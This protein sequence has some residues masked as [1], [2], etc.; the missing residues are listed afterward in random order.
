MVNA[1]ILPPACEAP[2]P[3]PAWCHLL[4]DRV[5]GCA[6]ALATFILVLNAVLTLLYVMVSRRYEV[7]L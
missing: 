7:E 6:L 1:G 4:T 5:T 2:R 3:D